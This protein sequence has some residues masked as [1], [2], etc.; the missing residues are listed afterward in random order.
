MP[1]S[2]T[3]LDHPI[4]GN[5]RGLVSSTGATA[6]AT[7]TV[8][9]RG[10]KFAEIP[11]RWRDP[12]LL[13]GRL[14]DTE[15]D[16]TEFGPECPQHLDG[17]AFDLSL[18]GNVQVEPQSRSQSELESLNLIITSPANVDVQTSSL[19]VLVW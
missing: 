3:T 17:M 19:P 16:C 13:S 4:L 8:Q 5:L 6:T 10:I 14:S 18:L 12:I 7:A 1:P 11:G 15:Y 2:Y 9:Y